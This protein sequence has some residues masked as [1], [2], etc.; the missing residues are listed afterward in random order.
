MKLHNHN[1]LPVPCRNSSKVYLKDMTRPEELTLF[2]PIQATLNSHLD[3]C[4]TLQWGT[5]FHLCPLAIFVQHDDP[6]NTG[7]RS[8][9]TSAQNLA[10]V[11]LYFLFLIIKTQVTMAQ[12]PASPGPLLFTCSNI[13]PLSLYANDPG[14]QFLPHPQGFFNTFR[15]FFQI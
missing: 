7:I 4:N 9:H 14:P 1:I 5:C 12:S 2:C 15:I 3:R 11:S 6:I 8:E 13:S 10:V